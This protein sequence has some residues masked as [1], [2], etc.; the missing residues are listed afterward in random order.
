MALAVLVPTV[1]ATTA[2]GVLTVAPFPENASCPLEQ[3]VAPLISAKDIVLMATARVFLR[4][5]PTKTEQS[6]YKPAAQVHNATQVAALP[7]E[8]A[9][10][11]PLC[12]VVHLARA[13]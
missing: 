5:L 8:F 2:R 4:M 9:P 3:N 1:Q 10:P 6:R 7:A 13:A 12:M 11:T